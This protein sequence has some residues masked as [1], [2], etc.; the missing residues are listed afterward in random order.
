M[1]D[2]NFSTKAVRAGS[3]RSQAGE[4]SEGIYVTS[5]F[6]FK[7]AHEAHSRF[8][9]DDPGMVYS[10]FSNPSTDMFEKRLACLENAEDCVST[11]SGMSAILCCCLAFLKSGDE[12][13]TTPSL[14][15]ATI[16][17]FNS[18]LP[19]YGI[20]VK[21]VRLTNNQEWK[22]AVNAN[23]KIIYLETPSNPLN[24]IAD[25]ASI[26]EI[27]K[28]NKIISIVDNCL[29]T[30]ALQR[31]LNFSIDLVLHS[32]TKFIDGQGRVLG[33]AIAGRKELIDKLRGIVRTCGPCLSSFNAW[34]LFKS[35]E[36]LKIRMNAQS[37]S[38]IKIAQWLNNC[39]EVE[40]V[41][42]PGLLSR[43]QNALAQ[44]QQSQPGC[45]IS[46]S[47][48]SQKSTGLK[49]RAWK[50]IDNI[51]LFSKTG[52]LGDSRSTITHPS[53]TTHGRITEDER[54]KAGIHSGLIRL[55]IGLEDASDL[56]S[57]LKNSLSC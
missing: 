19:R 54:E 39:N 44:V 56:I 51:Q 28:K 2:Y 40:K 8:I 30:P 18:I 53:T 11:S 10:R 22:S 50:I 41:F 14:F 27:S 5:S 33:G 12:I 1:K 4:H 3:Y 52:N 16:Q 9:G 57:D 45:I 7:S 31:P 46:F 38:A 34:V 23:T 48:K 36:T 42:F 29:C 13:L 35:L 24:E 47:I 17:L 6:V 20:T 43:S 21:Y 15:G 55:S 25:L 26:A 49:D 37:E 32:A